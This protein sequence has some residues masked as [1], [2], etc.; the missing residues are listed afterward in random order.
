MQNFGLLTFEDGT[1]MLS[2]S[3]RNS[4]EDLSSPLLRGRSVKSFP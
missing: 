2:R 3:L 1:D 4:T